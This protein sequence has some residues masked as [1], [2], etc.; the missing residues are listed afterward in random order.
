MKFLF[1]SLVSFSILITSCQKR[2]GQVSLKSAAT[3]TQVYLYQDTDCFFIIEG[4][5]RA[6]KSGEIDS[7]RFI[8]IT[9][10]SD[11]PY[12]YDLY[13]FKEDTLEFRLRG[14]L[15]VADSITET[16]SD[17]TSDYHFIAKLSLYSNNEIDEQVD[18][19]FISSINP[20][21]N[22]RM[23]GQLRNDKR[24]GKWLEYYDVEQTD[25]GRSSIF[26]NGKRHG[27]D[28]VFKKGKLYILSHWDN[29]RKHGK[30]QIYW[31]NGQTKWETE[32]KDGIQVSKTYI[33]NSAGE[34]T[35]S[36]E[37]GQ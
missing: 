23:V 18:T 28:S 25:L 11:E 12:A 1:L 30:F 4:L 17:E 24:E 21:T 31:P 15:M 35:N 29:G 32:Y 8:L 27:R 14:D 13:D 3:N 19:L 33:F 5:N 10:F 6:I 37:I 20:L 26:I 34:L 9:S 22:E 36:L 2:K 16:F 7:M